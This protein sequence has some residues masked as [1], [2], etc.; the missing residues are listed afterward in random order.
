VKLIQRLVRSWVVWLVAGFLVLAGAAGAV[1]AYVASRPPVRDVRGSSTQEFVTTAAPKV[2]TSPSDRPWPMYG[3]DPARTHTA[4][5]G[6]RPPF[7][8]V[9]TF[10][11]WNEIEFP[12]AIGYGLVFVSQRKG[13]F[14]ALDAR[15][16]RLVWEKHFLHCASASPAVG[17]NIVYEAYMQPYPCNRYPRSQRGFVVAMRFRNRHGAWINGRILW[18]YPSGVVETSPLLVGKT[19]YWGTWDGRLYALDVS[20]PRRPR[21]RWSF[22]ADAEIDSSP[23][24]A[25]GRIFFGTNGGHVYALDARTG[26]ERWRAASFSSFLHGREYF[27]ATPTLAFGRVYIGNTDGTL[28]VFGQRTGKLLWAKHAG[29]YV[30]TAAAVWRREVIVGTY[31]GALI[32]YNAATGDELWR[33]E[34]PA[35]IHGSP[36]VVN[37]VVYF[38]T[39]GRCG[40]HGSRYAKSGPNGTY[41]VEAANGRLLWSFRDGQY[42]PVVA[43]AK[44][45]YVAGFQRVYAFTRKTG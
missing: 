29:S 30:Y 8:G 15:N 31:D 1:T 28:Y 7:R 17:H 36:S 5:F 18:R 3:L 35:A 16:G 43:D 13:R 25:N 20:R 40:S 26:R 33:H 38:S 14:F 19:L 39:C 23:A 21:L 41:A 11:V 22:Q 45:L 32:A 42:S 27:Y 9:W 4:G 44:R 37:N 24:Y 6:V 10:P 12:P 34:A 2:I